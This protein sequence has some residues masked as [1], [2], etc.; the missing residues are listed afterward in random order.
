MANLAYPQCQYLT[1]TSKF[2]LQN[3][4]SEYRLDLVPHFISKPNEY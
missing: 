2:L 3:I 1:V 4:V